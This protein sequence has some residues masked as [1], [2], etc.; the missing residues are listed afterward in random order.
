MKTF[1]VSPLN[2]QVV[3][4]TQWQESREPGV[5]SEG[6]TVV[7]GLGDPAAGAAEI[8]FHLAGTCHS[9]QNPAHKSTVLDSY[10]ELLRPFLEIPSKHSAKQKAVAM[11][12]GEKPHG[13]WGGHPGGHAVG[14]ESRRQSDGGSLPFSSVSC[15]KEAISWT[16]GPFGI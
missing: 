16:I 14:T 9:P 12:P 3:V 5:L 6:R 4:T 10:S 2:L 15:L 8:A 1:Q 13:G 11:R 7:T